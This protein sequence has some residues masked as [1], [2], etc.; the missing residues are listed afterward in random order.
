MGGGGGGGGSEDEETEKLRP[1]HGNA[2][3]FFF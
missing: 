2:C 1:G 3:K